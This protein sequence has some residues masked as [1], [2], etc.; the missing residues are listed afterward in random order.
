MLKLLAAADASKVTLPKYV[1]GNLE[2]LPSV[3]AGEVDVYGLPAAVK[4]LT[5]Q[6]DSLSKQVVEAKKP[7]EFHDLLMRVKVLESSCTPSAQYVSTDDTPSSDST[8]ITS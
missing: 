2:R 3:S 6:V 4:K 8:A 7:D 5:A 1:A